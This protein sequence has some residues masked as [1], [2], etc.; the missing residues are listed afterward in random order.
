MKG[1]FVF[2]AD[3]ETD[4]AETTNLRKQHPEIVEKLGRMM[5]AVRTPSEVF[6]LRPFDEAPAEP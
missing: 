4:P 3:L 1:A 2:L 6:P 5:A